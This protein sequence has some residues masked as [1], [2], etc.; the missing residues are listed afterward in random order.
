MALSKA[1][2]ERIIAKYKWNGYQGFKLPYGLE[3]P[4]DDRK[5]T[6]DAIF[7]DG[8]AGLRVL[9]IG[10]HYGAM[11]HFALANSAAEAIGIEARPKYACAARD[12]ARI[13]GDGAMIVQDNVE[14]PRT[15]AVFQSEAVL[16]LN[17]N[18]HF[19]YPVA[20]LEKV[21][22]MATSVLAVE[23]PSLTEYN[24]R[25]GVEGTHVKGPRDLPKYMDTVDAIFRDQFDCW[26]MTPAAME[27][28]LGRVWK[29]EMRTIPSPKVETRWLTICTL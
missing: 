1:E 23:Y 16:L 26:W 15:R 21:A 6:F 9:D 7:P 17:V 3:I 5:P 18:H 19:R 25:F 10:C 28:A 4:G 24:S 29:G 14:T 22:K 27:N 12:I 13:Y 20:S 2:V 8:C 11:L